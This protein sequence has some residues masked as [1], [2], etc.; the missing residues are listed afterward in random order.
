[1]PLISMR[2]TVW[3][4]WLAE[5]PNWL[6]ILSPSR[7]PV[8]MALMIFCSFS[9]SPNTSRES[10]LALWGNRTPRTSSVSVKGMAPCLMSRLQ[11]MLEGRVMSPG[12]ANTSLP[13]SRAWAAVIE[14]P[15]RAA[16]STMTMASARPLMMRLRCGK[17]HSLVGSPMPYSDKI[18]P[19]TKIFFASPLLVTG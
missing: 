1:M 18:A 19:F 5:K 2:V 4:N 12:T 3:L 9:L 7:M 17:F 13:C 15:L 10:C 8:L 16:A 6:M 11:P 14:L